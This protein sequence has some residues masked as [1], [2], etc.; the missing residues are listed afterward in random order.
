MRSGL[1]G[2]RRSADLSFKYF[3]GDHSEEDPPVPIPNTEV[4]LFS[5]DGTAWVTM[6]ES[7]SS[8][9]SCKKPLGNCYLPRGFFFSTIRRRRH[10]IPASVLWSLVSAL[11][12]PVSF[13]YLITPNPQLK[14]G[15]CCVSGVIRFF[16]ICLLSS[17]FSDF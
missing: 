12:F 10:I 8:P 4:K 1:I 17:D 5:A 14:V 11:P 9:N 16:Y 15:R 7:R 2:K 13:F 3:F 6:W